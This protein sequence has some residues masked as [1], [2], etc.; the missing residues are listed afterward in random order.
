LSDE[1]A[2]TSIKSALERTHTL[3]TDSKKLRQFIASEVSLLNELLEPAEDAIKSYSVRYLQLF[4]QV[5]AHT[6][7]VQQQIKVLNRHETYLALTKLA[8]VKALGA[9]SRSG[10]EEGWVQ[11]VEGPPELF[12][13]TLTHDKVKQELNAMPQPP[14][15]PLTIQNAGDWL[16]RAD[17]ALNK[18]QTALQLALRDKATL[19]HS[20]ALRERLKQGQN[21]AFIAGLLAAPS[22]EEMVTYLAQTLGSSDLADPDPIS[23]LNRFL[24]QIR[25]R[26]LRLTNFSPGK[27]TI[28]ASDIDQ[29]V[30]EFRQFLL[31]ALSTDGDD[32]LSVIE[33]E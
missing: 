31:A 33:L 3:L 10:L 21:E 8:Q 9:D 7:Q 12:P 32:E 22:V 17:D 1:P 26:K 28:E 25:I 5:T 18:C 4:D 30:A 2:L 13:M 15:C 27:Q 16:Q 24:K 20:E 23:L 6:E 14:G 29:I 11:A 19:L